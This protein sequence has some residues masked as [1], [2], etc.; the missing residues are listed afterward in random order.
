MTAWFRVLM[1]ELPLLRDLP[2]LGER[3]LPRVAVTLGPTVPGWLLR[4]AAAVAAAAVLAIAAQG[5]GTS[6]G[7][8]WAMVGIAAAIMA[9]WPSTAAAHTAVVVGGL[10]VALDAHGPFDPVV[11]ALIPLAYATVRLAWWAERVAPAARIE[12][13]ALGRGLG[14]GAT[15]VGGTLALGGFAFL[16]AGRPSAIGVLAGGVAL[17]ALTWLVLAARRA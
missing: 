13:A 16:F 10:L 9:V 4:A 17:V 5:V 11:F 7:L 6:P 14:R 12:L 3:P 8:A 1:T 15:L 2:D